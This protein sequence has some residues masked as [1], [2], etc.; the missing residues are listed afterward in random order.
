MLRA[1]GFR[2]TRGMAGMPTAVGGEAGEGGTVIAI[3]GEYDARPGLC[4][5]AGV[6]VRQPLADQERGKA[7]AIAF[8]V[9]RRFW[10]RSRL[11]II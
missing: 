9:R 5:P 3:L 10:R 11:R 1:E 7:A 4:Q 2:T 6:A 8:L